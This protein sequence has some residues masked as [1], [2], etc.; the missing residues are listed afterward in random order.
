MRVNPGRAYSCATASCAVANRVDA[1]T[2][3]REKGKGTFVMWKTVVG[4][5][6]IIAISFVVAGIL[7]RKAFE[8]QSNSNNKLKNSINHVIKTVVV[9]IMIV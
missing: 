5:V 8:V 1:N 6:L 4:L 9:V 7:N 3:R 2:A